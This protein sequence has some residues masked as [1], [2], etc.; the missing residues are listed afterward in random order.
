M[1][2][3]PVPDLAA[4]ASPPRQ[5]LSYEDL[6]ISEEPFGAGGQA[7]VYEAT[8]TGDDEPSKVALKEPKLERAITNDVAESFLHEAATWQTIDRRE[9]EKPR[10]NEYEHIVGV[11]DTGGKTTPMDRDGIYGWRGSGEPIGRRS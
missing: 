4:A 6:E 3:P 2:D 11:I 9:R 10:W 8:L 7:I 1:S 5:S